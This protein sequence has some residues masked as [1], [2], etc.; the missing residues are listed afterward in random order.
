MLKKLLIL[1]MT[2]IILS[3][4]A[5]S[6]KV[7]VDGYPLAEREYIIRSNDI[8]VRYIVSRWFERNLKNSE[9]ELYPQHLKKDTAYIFPEDTKSV[10]FHIMVVN[11]ENISYQVRYKVK[12]ITDNTIT[13]TDYLTSYSGQRTRNMVN[14][15]IPAKSGMNARVE[16]YVSDSKGNKIIDL[17]YIFFKIIQE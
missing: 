1:I 16:V 15:S 2:I 10:A 5:R 17:G 13:R 12:H 7:Y 8:S 9:E 4:C 6:I 14:V 11:P 3:G